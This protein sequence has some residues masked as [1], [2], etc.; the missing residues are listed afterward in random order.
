VELSSLSPVND[1]TAP[2]IILNM[3]S[4][5]K[6]ESQYSNAESSAEEKNQHL[7]HST[8]QLDLECSICLESV[9]KQ[10][11]QFGLLRK[12][13]LNQHLNFQKLIFNWI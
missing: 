11:K 8:T 10:G 9:L 12:S 2:K 6:E 7:E 4:T 1:D 13:R 5:D 3:A